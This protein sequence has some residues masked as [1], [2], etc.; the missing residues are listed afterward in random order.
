MHWIHHDR[1]LFTF[2][3]IPITF[4]I[5]NN[6]TTLINWFVLGL[7]RWWH[8]F[9]SLLNWHN[10][11][12]TFVIQFFTNFRIYKCIGNTS[13]DFQLAYLKL[14]SMQSFIW[15]RILNSCVSDRL[16]RKAKYLLLQSKENL[17]AFLLI[18]ILTIVLFFCLQHP[19]SLSC[20]LK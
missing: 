9:D 18:A 17:I 2:I 19:F 12:F 20:I 7:N 16:R 11:Y 13:K 5:K 8:S 6:T 1:N 3:P 4:F 15:C 10:A 14:S